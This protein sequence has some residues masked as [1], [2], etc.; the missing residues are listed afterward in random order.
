MPAGITY[1]NRPAAFL[2]GFLTTFLS[3][4]GECP[5]EPE[6]QG[7]C[8]GPRAWRHLQ[9]CARRRMGTDTTPEAWSGL[10]SSS[11]QP[12]QALG[13]CVWESGAALGAVLGVLLSVQ[14]TREGLEEYPLCSALWGLEQ[15]QLDAGDRDTVRILVGPVLVQQHSSCDGLSI[16]MALV[17]AQPAPRHGDGFRGW[18]GPLAGWSASLV[19]FIPHCPTFLQQP[20]HQM[21]C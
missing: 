13:A 6:A 2:P 5:K 7:P 10:S 20:R 21:L 15:P 4:Q 9:P 19:A 8:S 17:P 3:L 1:C 16:H 11:A 14:P 12:R 18:P